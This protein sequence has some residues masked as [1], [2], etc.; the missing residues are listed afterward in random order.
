MYWKCLDIIKEL[1][2]INACLKTLS[3]QGTAH[4]VDINPKI[5]KTL[6]W[7][8][9]YAC[10]TTHNCMTLYELFCFEVKNSHL[11]YVQAF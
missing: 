5:F 3:F 8:I 4:H 7:Y 2:C 11:K 1:K 6:L 10:Q 9:F